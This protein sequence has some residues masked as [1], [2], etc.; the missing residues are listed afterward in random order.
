MFFLTK[1]VYSKKKKSVLLQSWNTLIFLVT[2]ISHGQHFHKRHITLQGTVIVTATSRCVTS[3]SVQNV[4][5]HD[6]D[7]ICVH[8]LEA[9][10]LG[11]SIPWWTDFPGPHLRHPLLLPPEK[12]LPPGICFVPRS[13]YLGAFDFFV[14]LH[15]ARLFSPRRL[16][17]RCRLKA[18]LKAPPSMNH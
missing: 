11:V 9:Y 6:F 1:Y 12:K 4:A 14:S 16:M 15:S 17:N 2:Q 3:G 5:S 8:P 10:V 7:P 18:S 13:L